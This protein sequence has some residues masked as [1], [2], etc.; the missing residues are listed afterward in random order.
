MKPLVSDPTI[1]VPQ[2]DWTDTLTG[3]SH[4][5]SVVVSD[6]GPDSEAGFQQ[7]LDNLRNYD[8]SHIATDYATLKA[9]SAKTRVPQQVYLREGLAHV[10]HTYAMQLGLE[11][12][13]MHNKARAT[14][15]QFATVGAQWKAIRRR[16]QTEGRAAGARPRR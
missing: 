3:D 6:Y 11:R 16:M 5:I 15:A 10:L 9:L 2:R 13:A 12:E 7:M 8:T 4:K 14:M 1:V